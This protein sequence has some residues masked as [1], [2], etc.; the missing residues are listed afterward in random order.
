MTSSQRWTRV[1][2]TETVKEAPARSGSAI[3]SPVAFVRAKHQ[4]RDL[5]LGVGE[6]LYGRGGRL[7][8][9]L[10][11]RNQRNGVHPQL[12]VD[13]G[14]GLGLSEKSGDGARRPSLHLIRTHVFGKNGCVNLR[15]RIRL[16][17]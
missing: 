16:S 12:A 14:N 10:G 8:P 7:E 5:A 2:S 11:L 13:Q 3:V 17:Y 4:M 15:A 1:S 9:R 6:E